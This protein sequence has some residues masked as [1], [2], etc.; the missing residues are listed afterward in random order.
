[1]HRKRQSE[2][3][4]L[5]HNLYPPPLEAL[6]AFK[7][8]TVFWVVFRDAIPTDLESWKGT[9]INS[10]ENG[11]PARS[12]TLYCLSYPAHE[13][14]KYKL[15]LVLVGLQEVKCDKGGTVPTDS[16]IFVY[17]NWNAHHLLRPGFFVHKGTYDILPNKMYA[18][19]V[20]CR[21]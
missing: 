10:E 16:Y 12:Q 19:W 7:L 1:M 13:L 21:M 20:G 8:W 6:T 15:D 3:K 5:T 14:A 2:E 17:G 9:G 4:V 18:C 11:R